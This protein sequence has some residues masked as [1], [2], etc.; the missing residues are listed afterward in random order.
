MNRAM[1]LDRA[2]SAVAG[3]G[4]TYPVWQ[5]N[6]TQAGNVA[7]ALV[8]ILSAL[9]LALQIMGYVRRRFRS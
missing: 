8:P 1:V 7:Q 6:L 2:T 4:I 9:W 5:E 3:A